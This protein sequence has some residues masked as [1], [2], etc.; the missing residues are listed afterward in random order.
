[1]MFPLTSPVKEAFAAITPSPDMAG[2]K[3]LHRP[4]LLPAVPWR[5]VRPLM[6]TF[7]PYSG[8]SNTLNLLL[9][10]L[11]S[12]LNLRRWEKNKGKVEQ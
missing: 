11:N 10:M 12:L 2:I 5:K 4:T 7:E 1:M 8:M 3:A 6:V 9:A